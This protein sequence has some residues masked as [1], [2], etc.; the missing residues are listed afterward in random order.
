MENDFK[1][2]RPENRKIYSQ[3]KLIH[4]DNSLTLILNKIL[5]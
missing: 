5:L 3:E 1:Q 2:E 4:Q